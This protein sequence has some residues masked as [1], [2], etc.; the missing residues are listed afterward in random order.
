MLRKI[1]NILGDFIIRRAGVMAV[2]IIAVIVLSAIAVTR[3]ETN[4]NQLDLLP[5]ELESVRA[6]NQLIEM[7]GGVGFFIV[8][9]K[10]TDEAHLKNVA[11]DLTERL[12]R[13]PGVQKAQC[14]LDLDF[15][16]KHIPYYIETEDLEE[17]LRRVRKAIRAAIKR[18][19]G[20]GLSIS[21]EE[22]KIDFKDIIA[23]YENLDRRGTD[24]P[25][26]IDKSRSLLIIMLQPRGNPGDI[27]FSES[28][29]ANIQKTIEDYNKEN[30][31]SA[32]LKE[33]YRGNV[34]GATVTYGFT[35]DYKANI[36]D[37]RIVAKALAPTSM[38][39]FA[40][41]LLLLIFLLRNP[42]H[43]AMLMSTLVASVLMTYAFCEVAIGELN[44]ITVI[45]GAIIMGFGI[46]FGLYFMYR[47]RE[48][49]TLTG[50]LQASIS[51]TLHSAG[52]SSL[53]SGLISACS[54]FILML[55]DF[56]GFSQFG[57]MAGAGVLLTALMMYF[58]LPVIFVLADRVNPGFKQSLVTP[59]YRD[60]KQTDEDSHHRFPFAKRIL[61]VSLVLTAIL[62]FFAFRIK[63]DYDGRS[64]M[65]ADSP[66]LILQ[67]EITEKFGIASDPA[68][69]YSPDLEEA[70]ALYDA[71]VPLPEGSTVDSVLSIH[72]LVPSI[73]KQQANIEV[74]KEIKERVSNVP[75]DML[76]SDSIEAL[77][78]IDQYL[79]V[80][81]FTMEDVPASLIEQFK[82]VK[83][84][85]YAE[86]YLTLLYPGVSVW[87]GRELIRFAD[88]VGTIKAG[89]KIYHTA[90]G[91][92]LFAD[93]A[94]IV[95]SDGKKF[96]LVI[97]LIVI[98]ILGIAFRNVRAVFYS[99]I[100]LLGG[101]VW[102]LGLMAMFGWKINFVN[103]VVFPVVFGYG[104]SL[105]VYLYRRYNESGS[106]MLS[107]KRT[108]AAIA[109]SSVTTLVGWAALLVSGHNGLESMGI[110]AFF[111]IAAAMVL[112]FTV[113]PALLEITG[114]KVDGED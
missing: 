106:V 44:T 61:I 31:H 47:I 83:D 17:I 6:T 33:G 75:R 81:T 9:L 102:M 50:N 10:G 109:G 65:T 70:K 98:I 15:I 59:L 45:L 2:A 34:Q 35:G 93:L 71:L 40:G 26:F 68:V 25:Y 3:L 29:L 66:S 104:V 5:R 18:E 24:D 20:F 32:V 63:F 13:V 60:K 114:A 4:Y 11:D 91:A 89:D 56:K 67:E 85:P 77:G 100:P 27:V 39:A 87:D 80:P 101:M 41:I 79:K 110:L 1:S 72:T 49:F 76:D 113:L 74:L 53:I 107:V 14:R 48:E 95:L 86:G 108:G 69:V 90:G 58:T 54:F 78:L 97:V 8:G 111:G 19:T 16:H 38:F 28:L 51:A 36:D 73:E 64:F 82:P 103:I 112:T 99:I 88:E 57:L 92:V 21:G 37:A 22:E 52:T 94:R 84:S 12:L 7:V 62:S 42:W 55:S 23:K 30:T 46:D 105:G 96:S 43:I